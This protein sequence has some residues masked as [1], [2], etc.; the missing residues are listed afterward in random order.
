MGREGKDG[1]MEGGVEEEG[2][3]GLGGRDHLLSPN[4]PIYLLSALKQKEIDLSAS[5][6]VEP[7]D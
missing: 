1:V 5:G 7:R 2:G 3:G 6:R 4:S